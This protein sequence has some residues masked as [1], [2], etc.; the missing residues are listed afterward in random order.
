MK[1]NINKI[2]KSGE[3]MMKSIAKYEELQQYLNG[4]KVL[5]FD[6]DG[7]IANTEPYHWKTYNLLLKKYNVELKDNNIIKY[8]GN[9]EFFIYEMIKKDLGIEFDN[10]DFLKKRLETYME[11]II[12]ENLRPYEIIEQVIKEHDSDKYILS[13]QRKNVITQLL[14]KWDLINNF[15]EIFSVPD[16][17][18]TKQEVISNPDMFNV[19]NNDVVLFE[20]CSKYLKIASENNILAVGVKNKYLP[21]ENCDL[22]IEV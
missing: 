19:S 16:S 5:L 2:L 8:I 9:E 13:S 12:K 6:L 18:V 22:L 21:V 7:T 17:K 20:D 15:K 4:K 11:L 3:F 14:K 10:H 1:Y